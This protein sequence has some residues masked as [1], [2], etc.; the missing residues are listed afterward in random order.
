MRIGNGRL[1]WILACSALAFGVYGL[2]L[3]D[4]FLG[5]DFDLIVSFYGEAPSYFFKLLFSNE[6]GVIWKDWGIDPELGRGYIRPLKIWLLKLDLLV[7]GANPI[8]FHLTATT[9][10]AANLVL[11]FLILDHLLPGRRIFAFL[12]A[13]LTAIHPIFAEIVP[14][15][16]AREETLASLFVLASFYALLRFRDVNA[17]PVFFTL[18]YSLGLM[19]KESALSALALGLGWDLVHGNLRLWRRQERHDALRLYGPTAIVLVIYFSLRWVAFGN[20]KGGDG[21]PTGFDSVGAF[22]VFHTNFFPSLVRSD[23]LATYGLPHVGVLITA[24]VVV[25]LGCLLIRRTEPA[26]WRQILFFGPVW[27]LGSMSTLYG[28]YFTNRHHPTLVIGVLLFGVLVL[29]ELSSG[30]ALRGQRAAATA[31]FTLCALAFLPP[32]LAMSRRF[33]EASRT[34]HSIH[35]QIEEATAG[36]PDGSAIFVGHVPQRQKPPWYF[37]WGFLSS[38]KKPFTESDLATRSVVINPR[39]LALTRSHVQPPQEYDLRLDFRPMP[40]SGSPVK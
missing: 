1:A 13:A 8:G 37:G 35:A 2:N 36:L 22:L 31:A 27:Y 23:L 32:T 20:F 12:G 4:Y 11:V 10:F 15:V 29:A 6:S 3:N 25:A 40:S 26:R 39:N 28:T 21:N 9:I 34:V 17:S 5:D 19:T 30:L 16:T 7:W 14:F 33:D 18:F 24:T 38:L